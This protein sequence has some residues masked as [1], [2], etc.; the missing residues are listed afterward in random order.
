MVVAGSTFYLRSAHGSYLSCKQDGTP[1]VH[2]G[3]DKAEQWTAVEHEGKL[4]IK[5]VAHGFHLGAK[6]G[7]G[8]QV[9]ASG[10][11]QAWEQWAVE[12]KDGGKICLCSAHN[13]V[14]GCDDK[15]KLYMTGNRQGWEQWDYEYVGLQFG[16]K[17]KIVCWKG[18]NLGAKDDWQ[19]KD[20]G[21]LYVSGNDQAW[22]QWSIKSAGGSKLFIVSG[23]G[24]NLGARPGDGNVAYHSGNNQAWEQWTMVSNGK[25]QYHL[26]SEHGTH[27]GVD[28]DGKLYLTGNK[29]AWETWSFAHIH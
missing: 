24:S 7:D 23:H 22:E 3:Q 20:G 28:N 13:T 29:Q 21:T 14:V 16:V 25:G 9:Y 5:N 18:T 15:H 26:K 4:L 2:N 27:L 12:K 1:H 19:N 8:D 17:Y 11:N 10:N 6:P